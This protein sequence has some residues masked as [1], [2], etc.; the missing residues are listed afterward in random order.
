MIADNNNSSS[1]SPAISATAP[2]D[3]QQ[4]QQTAI[5]VAGKELTEN[6]ENTNGNGNGK[7]SPSHEESDLQEWYVTFLK[8]NGKATQI[9]KAPFCIIRFV[10]NF[11]FKPSQRLSIHF[12]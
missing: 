11:Y 9:T 1:A 4:L 2:A 6:G 10:S 3:Q 12:F 8:N 5:T 7:Q